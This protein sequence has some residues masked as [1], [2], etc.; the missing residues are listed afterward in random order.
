MEAGGNFSGHV[1]GNNDGYR[2]IGSGCVH[3][4][5]QQGNAQLGGAGRVDIFLELF[6]EPGNAAVVGNH[7]RNAAAEKSQEEGF[8]HAG[9]TGPD[10]A[11]KG[12]DGQAAVG[13]ADDAGQEDTAHQHQ[14]Y[15]HSQKGKKKHCHIGKDL[16]KG[17][18]PVGCSFR[19]RNRSKEEDRN[20]QKGRRQGNQEIHFEFILQITALGAGGSNGGIGNHGQIVA[21]HG[22]AHAGPQKKGRRKAALFRHACR[23]RDNGCHRAHGG[24]CGGAHKSGNKENA[25]RQILGW[26]ETH[27]QIHGGIPS[28]HGSCHGGKSTGQNVDHEHGHDIVIA[29]ASGENAE[30]IHHRI[31]AET[32]GGKDGNKH[33]RYRR[34]L[35]ESHGNA[36]GLE[37]QTGAQI[38]GDKDDKRKKGK[39]IALPGR[40]VFHK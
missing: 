29:G 1:A 34:K 31:P 27:T 39:G 7:F 3:Q 33:G 25:Y 10:L 15:V 6:N 19:S 35:V 23:N 22:T 18:I 4:G 32:E 37:I 14:E 20:G 40:F 16:P 17:K 36:S 12:N 5:H 21:K 38:D 28:A 24:T 9:K 11:G 2:V 8:I 26:N 30:F 13:Q